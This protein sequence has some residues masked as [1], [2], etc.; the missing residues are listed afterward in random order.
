MQSTLPYKTFQWGDVL[1]S[2]AP[3]PCLSRARKSLTDG[4][5][6][7]FDSNIQANLLGSSL[8]LY[9]SRTLAQRRRHRR[10]LATLYQPLDD[11]DLSDEEEM[12]ESPEML[13]SPQDRRTRA[14]EN[15]VWD[16]AESE[17]FSLG[18]DEG[19]DDEHAATAKPPP[20]P[21]KATVAE[22]QEPV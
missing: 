6:T 12:D 21:K 10:E 15:N 8:G 7:S 17:I 4:V 20:T 3:W 13:E 11:L 2:A 19:S 9:I 14:K 5:A 1:V 22:G 16:D 18:G